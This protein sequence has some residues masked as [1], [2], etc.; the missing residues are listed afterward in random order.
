MY[1]YRFWL[2]PRTS[3]VRTGLTAAPFA[4]R[5]PTPERLLVLT[6]VILATPL[7]PAQAESIP[8]PMTYW[9]PSSVLK[10]ATYFQLVVPAA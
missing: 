5:Q 10:V 9:E 7:S 1:R 2:A 6:P 8:R 4:S 3:Q